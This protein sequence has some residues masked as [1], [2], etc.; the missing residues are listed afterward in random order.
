MQEIVTP[1]SKIVTRV[2]L[3]SGEVAGQLVWRVGLVNAR[4]AGRQRASIDVE[5][6]RINLTPGM[7]A[8]AEIKTGQRRVVGDLHNPIQRGVSEILG[9]HQRNILD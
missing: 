7:S 3:P 2:L 6:K 4:G 1:M 5:E 8:T 9:E